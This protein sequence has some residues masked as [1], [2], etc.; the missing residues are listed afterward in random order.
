MNIPFALLAAVILL[1]SGAARNGFVLAGLAVEA[2][3]LVLAVRSHLSP[4]TDRD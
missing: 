3:G 4:G 2:L 1:P